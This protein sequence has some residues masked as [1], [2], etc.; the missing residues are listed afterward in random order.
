VSEYR[1][2]GRVTK[3]RYAAPPLPVRV[4]QPNALLL[5]RA[6][7]AQQEPLL[8]MTPHSLVGGYQ[9]LEE[10]TDSVFI[11]NLTLKTEG[12]RGSLAG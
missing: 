8:V 6:S 3:E 11:P 4:S 2:E 10:R 1:F 5:P 7:T 9:R 12:A